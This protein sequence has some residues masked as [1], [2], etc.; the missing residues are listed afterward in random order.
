LVD[1]AKRNELM[2]IYME[3]LS[4]MGL[5]ADD[6]APNGRAAAQWKEISTAHLHRATKG[7]KVLR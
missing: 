6:L 7:M 3:D 5:T 4:G 2:I 1:E